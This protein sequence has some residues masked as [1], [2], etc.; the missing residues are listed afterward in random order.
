MQIKTKRSLY[1]KAE[2]MTERRASAGK[3]SKGKEEK[4]WLGPRLCP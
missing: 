1:T 2:G 4:E 3:T